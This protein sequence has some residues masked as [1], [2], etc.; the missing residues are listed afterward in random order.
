M[1]I[2]PSGPGALIRKIAEN[3]SLGGAKRS[4]DRAIDR[5]LVRAGWMPEIMDGRGKVLHMS[6]TPTAI[7]GYLA[8]VLRRVNPSVVVHTGDLSDDIKLEL[9]PG[10]EERYHNAAKRLV[11][12]LAAP[13]RTVYLVLGNHD[14]ADLLPYLPDQFVLVDDAADFTI[15]GVMFSI[16]HYVGRT[17]EHPGRFNLFGHE[18]VTKS[19]A[20]GDD[21]Y[22]LNGVET[23]RLIDPVADEIE[24]IGYPRKTNDARLMRRGRTRC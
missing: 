7:Y 15:G 11:N 1:K 16:S 2:R 23:M 3:V 22:F 13:R 18:M 8:R 4:I 24:S 14:R 20:E 6:D 21:R 19:Y 10:E 12:I 5:G 17:R 9:Y